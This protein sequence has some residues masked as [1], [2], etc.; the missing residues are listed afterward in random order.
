MTEKNFGES[1]LN[2]INSPDDLK[3][4]KAEEIESLAQEIRSFLIERITENGGHLASNLGVVELT[5][6]DPMELALG[7]MISNVESWREIGGSGSTWNIWTS[8]K[9]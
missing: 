3:K 9:D 8:R 4:I 2:R 7:Q 6:A 5:L 1:L